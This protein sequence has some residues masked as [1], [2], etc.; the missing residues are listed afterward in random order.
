MRIGS[1]TIRLLLA[2]SKEFDCLATNAVFSSIFFLI[3]QLATS[4]SIISAMLEQQG[5]ICVFFVTLAE[6]FFNW[7]T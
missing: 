2:S 3:S 5:T 6:P 7:Q 1:Q 4:T